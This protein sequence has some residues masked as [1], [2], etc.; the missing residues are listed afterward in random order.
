MKP[1]LW[2]SKGKIQNGFQKHDLNFC[3]LIG[4]PIMNWR[5]VVNW[6]DSSCLIRPSRH[7]PKCM[8]FTQPITVG[9]TVAYPNGPSINSSWLTAM[10]KGNI[11]TQYSDWRLVIIN[12]N[13]GCLW[14]V[15]TVENYRYR[16]EY[17]TYPLAPNFKPRS[18][19]KRWCDLP[20][21]PVLLSH[22]TSRI[23]AQLLF[24]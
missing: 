11:I 24:F 18:W 5:A 12:G 10:A 23:G 4:V 16:A 9:F 17:V 2:Q 15:P 22:I 6:Y 3:Y 21:K 19:A 7:P 8:S 14:N 13:H 20:P 1:S